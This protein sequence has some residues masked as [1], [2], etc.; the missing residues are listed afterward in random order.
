[1]KLALVAILVG[2]IS[3]SSAAACNGPFDILCEVGKTIDRGTVRAG[4][5]I[6]KLN[7]GLNEIDPR[8][9]MLH[10]VRAYLRESEIPP[11]GVR[12][13]GVVAL[14]SRP[15]PANN[16]KLMMVC[17]SFIAH[18][19]RSEVSNAPI[20]DQMIT[21]WPLDDP[22]AEGAIKD[23]C[24]YITQHYVLG[25]ATTAI[26]YAEMQHVSLDGE[27]PFLI[28]WSPADSRGKSDKLVLVV[29]MSDSTDQAMIDHDFDFWK[30]KIVRDP[31]N[32]RRGFSLER[33]RVAIRDFVNHYG[34]D[35]VHDIKMAG[36]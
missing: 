13:Y 12:A 2:C 5:A 9:V 6:D 3:V 18:F 30:D 24:D 16:A 17:K 7:N 21:I 1:M 26:A 20:A 8:V 22:Q 15:T 35:I 23:D 14:K 4:K 25:A 11:T 19:D 34:S 27:G 28:G 36:L 33:V 32:W 31:S 29:D 10:P